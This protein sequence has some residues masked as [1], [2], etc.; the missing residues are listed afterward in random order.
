MD[1]PISRRVPDKLSPN[2]RAVLQGLQARP[3]L[4]NRLVQCIKLVGE[5]W[6]TRLLGQDREEALG[7]KSENLKPVP[8]SAFFYKVPANDREAELI[9]PVTCSV[10]LDGYGSLGVRIM[11]SEF[12]GLQ[13]LIPVY[14]RF[15][16]GDDEIPP[17]ENLRAITDEMF[18]MA[19]SPYEYDLEDNECVVAYS[20]YEELIKS[21]FDY[22]CLGDTG[23]TAVLGMH[24]DVRVCK[25]S[26]PYT[27]E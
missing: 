18:G 15:F 14:Q 26:F 9:V 23:K 20:K 19:T 11:Y 16:G 2:C 27:L 25:I 10:G 13:S 8:P 3:D 17:E 24:R 6:K 4:N 5:R 1:H 7:V 21:L 22:E 12:M